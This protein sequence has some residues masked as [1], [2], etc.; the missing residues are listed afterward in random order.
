MIFLISFIV[1]ILYIVLSLVVFRRWRQGNA[2]KLFAL[3]I[4][5]TGIWNLVLIVETW[6]VDSRYSVQ[7]LNSL[8]KI[9]FTLASAIAYVFALFT[10][11]F[12]KSN[13]QISRVYKTLLVIPFLASLGLVWGGFIF[14]TYST[15][16]TVYH[17]AWYYLYFAV[18]SFYFL[19]IA[20]TNLIKKYASSKGI[21]KLQ[22]KYLLVGYSVSIVVLLI[23]SFVNS[24]NETYPDI[25]QLGYSQ[26]MLVFISTCAY[27]VLKHRLMGLHYLLRKGTV[28]SAT[29]IILMAIYGYMLIGANEYFIDSFNWDRKLTY[30]FTLLLIVISF[31]PFR[32]WL[33]RALGATLFPKHDPRKKIIEQVRESV[34]GTYDIPAFAE[35][36]KRGAQRIC[37]VDS[38]LFVLDSKNKVFIGAHKKH[39]IKLDN[40]LVRSFHSQFEPIIMQEI[41][42]LLSNSNVIQ[43]KYFGEV[44]E[45]MR[46][47]HFE[48]AIPLGRVNDLMGILF[49]SPKNNGQPFT[50]EE[51]DSFNAFA[52]EASPALE[53]TLMYH[54]A[55]ARIGVKID[56]QSR[57]L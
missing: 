38:N 26:I 3:T 44:E 37:L 16:V 34:I 5:F 14:D 15:S 30:L 21:T 18:L 57:E 41:P 9:D 10:I 40:P 8:Q 19:L 56:M 49:V 17:L 23:L 28:Y 48:I 50:K 55:L 52:R 20:L 42:F 27:A 51:I 6:L 1:C 13:T 54:N 31:M 43:K 33:I 24:I 7:L 53:S 46:Q 35:A 25:D 32:S 4:L 36:L 29:L 11:Y 22:I 12:P 45:A 2:I 39:K 47:L